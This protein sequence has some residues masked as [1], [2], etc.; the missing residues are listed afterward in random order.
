MNLV[1]LPSNQNTQPSAFPKWVLHRV[2]C[3]LGGR[4]LAFGD[5]IVPHLAKAP[6]KTSINVDVMI[7]PSVD[8]VDANLPMLTDGQFDHAFVGPRLEIMDSP[9]NLM[10]EVVGKVKVGGH[11]TV[12]QKINDAKAKHKFDTASIH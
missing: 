1:Q 7:T 5:P 10:R 3:Y 4:G 12:V 11:L 6:T 9:E 8:I 2:A